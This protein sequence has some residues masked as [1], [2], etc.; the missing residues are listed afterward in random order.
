VLGALAPRGQARSGS[1]RRRKHD[2]GGENNPE[3]GNDTD[4]QDHQLGIL[5][6]LDRETKGSTFGV[7]EQLLEARGALERSEAG[8][9]LETLLAAPPQRAPAAGSRD[10]GRGSDEPAEQEISRSSPSCIPL[11]G[12][13]VPCASQPSGTFCST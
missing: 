1:S 11:H 9:A 13:I 7:L 3:Q 5:T 4:P 10:R 6:D 12:T 2:D 8:R